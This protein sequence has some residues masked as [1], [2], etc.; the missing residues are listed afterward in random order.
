MRNHISQKAGKEGGGEREMLLTECERNV[1]DLFF[2]H[3]GRDG[4]IGGGSRGPRKLSSEDWDGHR[5]EMDY[6]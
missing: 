2:R 3:F 4:A 1:E 6:D 5:G